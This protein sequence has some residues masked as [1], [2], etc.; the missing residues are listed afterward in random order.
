MRGESGRREMGSERREWEEGG[1]GERREWEEGDGR[2]RKGEPVLSGQL[3]V[4][5]NVARLRT[6]FKPAD[7]LLDRR[8]L[9][10]TD[11]VP[12]LPSCRLLGSS[13]T[14]QACLPLMLLLSPPQS[15]D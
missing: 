9:H 8:Y 5:L 13:T 1:G 3:F 2:E 10:D 15:T 4:V 7:F 14:L 6:H 11:H 12:R